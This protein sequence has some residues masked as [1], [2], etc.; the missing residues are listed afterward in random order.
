MIKKINYKTLYTDILNDLYPSKI[1]VCQEILDKKSLTVL[2][3]LELNQFIFG[4]EHKKNIEVN[5]KFKSYSR[6]D[7]LL[8]LD[9]QK[10]HQL[11]NAQLAHHFK[12]SRNTVT[13][14]KKIFI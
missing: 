11:N 13:K 1:S 3:I 12:L 5:Q 9:Y 14:W 10:K 4:D 2:D 7:I 8:I 6:Q